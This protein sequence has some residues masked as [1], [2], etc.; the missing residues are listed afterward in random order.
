[1][2]MLAVAVVALVA[3]FVVVMFWRTCLITDI[4][5]MEWEQGLLFS[6]GRFVRLVGAG[7]YRLIGPFL[8]EE[9]AKVDTRLVSVAVPGQE[10]L[11]KDKLPVRM[12]V[13]AQYRVADAQAALLKV[14]NYVGV[15]YEE[16]QLALRGLVGAET[17]EGLLERKDAVALGLAQ[18]LKPKAAE[19]GVDLSL[20]GLKDIVLPGEIKAIFT[21]V[22][23]AEKAAQASLITA[24]E[25]L[26]ATRCQ[27]NTAKLIAENPAILKLKELQ[28]MAELA[29][30]AGQSTVVFGA[31]VEPV[32]KLK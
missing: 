1:M 23:E 24:R 11:T 10:I 20:C 30:K 8:H 19:F 31:A 18:Q 14:Q 26:A 6:N 12:T 5:V 3:V 9:I 28:V 29:K 13:I 7:R 16:I 21:K 15:L 25:E 2:E 32:M 17:L 27:A 22:A 4:Q